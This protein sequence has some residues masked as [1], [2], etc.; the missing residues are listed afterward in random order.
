MLVDGGVRGWEKQGGGGGGGLSGGEVCGLRPVQP[1]ALLPS[2][3]QELP[4]AQLDSQQLVLSDGVQPSSSE[5]SPCRGAFRCAPF[6]TGRPKQGP[7]AL[8][9]TWQLFGRYFR[10]GV[11]H[12]D[13][14]CESRSNRNC[15]SSPVFP[16][17]PRSVFA[18]FRLMQK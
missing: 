17:R 11:N 3:H 8:F 16:E 6:G 13:R 18:E 15:N 5:C 12:T 1:W 2:R 9:K 4:L 10:S 14:N 7:L